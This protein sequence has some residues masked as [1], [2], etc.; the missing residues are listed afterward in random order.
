EW[1]G[2]KQSAKS[3]TANEVNQ[4][5]TTTPTKENE[6]T[7]TNQTET[8]TPVPQE[9]LVQMP[10]SEVNHQL[11]DKVA[12]LIVPKIQKKYSVYWG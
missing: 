1:Y 6:T 5:E 4:Y 7:N 9:E 11:G 3:L 8:M 12:Y 2:A 10:A